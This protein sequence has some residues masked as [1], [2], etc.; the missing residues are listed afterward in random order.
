LVQNEYLASQGIRSIKVRNYVLYY[1]V[2]EN[3]NTVTALRFLLGKR[4]WVGI[5][6]GEKP[7]PLA[8]GGL[9]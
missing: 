2:D 1:S 8:L 9:S 7:S 4:D 6:L 3:K 5:L